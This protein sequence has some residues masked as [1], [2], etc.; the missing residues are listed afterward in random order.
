M[1]TVREEMKAEGVQYEN[2]G[3]TLHSVAD[4]ADSALEAIERADEIARSLGLQK[5]RVA[6][7]SGTAAIGGPTFTITVWS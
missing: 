6:L 1:T 4:F 3:Y 7:H 2:Y 5:T